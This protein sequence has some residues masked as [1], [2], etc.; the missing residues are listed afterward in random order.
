[1]STEFIF[2]VTICATPINHLLAA[3]RGVHSIPCDFGHH[4]TQTAIAASHAI[5]YK[6]LQEFGRTFK[7]CF[8][9]QKNICLP[10]CQVMIRKDLTRKHNHIRRP[11]KYNHSM[12]EIIFF[13]SIR[14]SLPCDLFVVFMT[15]SMAARQYDDQFDYCSYFSRQ[16]TLKIIY[17][18][19]VGILITWV[20]VYIFITQQNTVYKYVF[21]TIRVAWVTW[22]A[23]FDRHIYLGFEMHYFQSTKQYNHTHFSQ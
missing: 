23:Q 2:L 12:V 22:V 19:Y 21:R 20:S 9:L 3:L 13:W 8:C 7:Q 17:D 16:N 14:S 15:A 10:L 5:P 6:E 4:G 1:M 18:K 11:I